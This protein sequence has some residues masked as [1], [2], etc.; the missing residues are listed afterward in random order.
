MT[1]PDTLQDL[2]EQLGQAQRE[3]DRLERER[4]KANYHRKFEHAR[5]LDR[6]WKEQ[7]KKVEQLKAQVEGMQ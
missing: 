4:H 6:S 1:A 3:A 7:R 5:F 2:K